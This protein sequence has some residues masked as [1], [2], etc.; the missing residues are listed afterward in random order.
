MSANAAELAPPMA[1]AINAAWTARAKVD[2]FM[3]YPRCPEFAAEAARVI[4]ARE[5]HGRDRRQAPLRPGFEGVGREVDGP[6]RRRP[7]RPPPSGWS[8]SRVA[9]AK[10]RPRRVPPGSSS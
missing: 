9:A 3:L 4:R 6:N 5:A 1:A 8:G 10:R 2:V 7:N